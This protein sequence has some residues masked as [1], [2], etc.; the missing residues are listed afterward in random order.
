MALVIDWVIIDCEDVE[1]MSAFWSAALDLEHIWTG[2]RGGH[3]LA[4]K[5]GSTCRL[6]MFPVSEAK[7]GKNRVHFDLRPEDQDDEVHR[8]EQLGVTRIDIGQ[9]DV[10]WVV[11]ADPEGN[12]F[13][14]PRAVSD[15]QRATGRW[16]DSSVRSPRARSSTPV[17]KR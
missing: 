9:G 4:A 1:K 13:C 10:S 7:A 5:D 14:I 6:A 8:L 11:M 2:P 16:G 15:E 12:E 17:S 3:L